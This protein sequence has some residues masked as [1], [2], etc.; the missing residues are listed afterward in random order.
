MHLLV[1]LFELGQGHVSLIANSQ[2]LL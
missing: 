2:S 1:H